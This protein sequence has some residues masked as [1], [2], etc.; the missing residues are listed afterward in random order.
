MIA[1]VEEPESGRLDES[2]FHHLLEVLGT[3]TTAT[4]E[5]WATIWTGY[6]LLPQTRAPD[7]PRLQL[8]GRR[9]VVYSGPFGKLL[10]FAQELGREAL[11]VQTPNHWWPADCSWFVGTEVDMDSTVIGCSE[12]L[13]RALV[14]HPGLEALPVSPEHDLTPYGDHVNWKRPPGQRSGPV[15]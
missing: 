7:L 4:D 2:S 12:S 10:D 14:A 15:D 6:G 5:C 3:T 13:A 1:D 11:V 8:P 9:Y